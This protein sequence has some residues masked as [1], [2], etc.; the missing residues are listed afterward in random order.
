MIIGNKKRTKKTR[1]LTFSYYNTINS[2]KDNKK[3]AFKKCKQKHNGNM[4]KQKH[5][6]KHDQL[7]SW[8]ETNEDHYVVSIIN[9]HIPLYKPCLLLRQASMKTSA[10]AAL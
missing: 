8:S 7:T 10:M 5:S 9:T 4:I 1:L 3:N 6:A 2:T